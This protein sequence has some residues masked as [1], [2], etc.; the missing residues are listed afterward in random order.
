MSTQ[1]NPPRAKSARDSLK[2]SNSAGGG[3]GSSSSIPSQ[4]RRYFSRRWTVIAVP[5]NSQRTESGAIVPLKAMCVEE[6]RSFSTELPGSSQ[7]RI[8]TRP[9]RSGLLTSLRLH[10]SSVWMQGSTRGGWD[11]P[12]SQSCPLRSSRS[13]SATSRSRAGRHPVN[14]LLASRNRTRL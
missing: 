4:E 14:W 12:G 9:K 5:C 11:S 13:L 3:N 10:V 8:M 6:P 7:N 2:I 1:P